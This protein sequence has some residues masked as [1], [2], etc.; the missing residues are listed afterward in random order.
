[1]GVDA[2]TLARWE[3]GERE[4]AGAF[5]ARATKFLSGSGRF[6]FSRRD[7]GR[8]RIIS[9]ALATLFSYCEPPGLAPTSGQDSRCT[10]S[11]SN[12]RFSLQW[13]VIHDFWNSAIAAVLVCRCLYAKPCS[14][15]TGQRVSNLCPVTRIFIRASR[16]RL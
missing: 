6:L 14:P 10:V 2:S 8:R 5:A 1:M 15:S 12:A 11:I 16:T 13:I 3:R 9:R 4:P 7:V